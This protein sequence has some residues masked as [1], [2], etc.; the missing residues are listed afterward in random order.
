MSYVLNALEKS[1]K[2]RLVGTIPDASSVGHHPIPPTQKTGRIVLTIGILLLL[3][4]GLYLSRS[5]TQTEPL[6]ST[7]ETH[8]KPMVAKQET[9]HLPERPLTATQVSQ[10]DSPPPTG[11]VEPTQR[12][13]QPYATATTN[14]YG[15]TGA[16]PTS[17]P[18]PTLSLSLSPMLT[19]TMT[20]PTQQRYK[21]HIIAK[22]AGVMNGCLIEIRSHQN[23]I[24]KVQL[25]GIT[26]LPP[27][28]V[29]GKEA[30]LFTT[31]AVFM[32]EVRVEV[33]QRR[34]SKTLVADVFGPKSGLLN[35]ALV[36][37]GL[38]NALDERFW[39]DEQEAR[40]ARR[41]MWYDPGVWHRI[42]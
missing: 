15:T 10:V 7:K 21:T 32:Q 8:K 42:P 34:G 41:G 37:E 9:V 40:T 2:E 38:V 16:T 5:D 20:T 35:Q 28:S 1:E 6:V 22:V 33:Q 25:A 13:A 23:R 14:A 11:R 12:A 17:R 18:A 36:R 19:S 27:Q 3:V 31:R 39:S 30:R 26:C 4:V 29:A 24:Q